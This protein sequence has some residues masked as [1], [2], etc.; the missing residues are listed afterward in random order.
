MELTVGAIVEGKVKSITNFG[1]F[2]SLPENLTGT[3][4]IASYGEN[5]QFL[6]VEFKNL[7]EPLTYLADARSVKIFLV[8]DIK[9]MIP[10]TESVPYP[11]Q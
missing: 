11:V 6:G 10:Q 7:D 8:D 2:V 1:A 5:D 3:L 9:T 4:M